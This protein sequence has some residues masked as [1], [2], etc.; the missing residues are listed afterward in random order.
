[1]NY[2][3]VINE[4]LLKCND[5]GEFLVSQLQ[6]VYYGLIWGNSNNNTFHD[7]NLCC[8]DGQTIKAHAAVLA[9]A[10][11]HLKNILMATWNP[12]TETSISLDD[13]KYDSFFFLS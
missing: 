4:V 10:S 11:L 9:V 1:M 2:F 13:F 7:V 3:N 6:E 5:P 8:K 12:H